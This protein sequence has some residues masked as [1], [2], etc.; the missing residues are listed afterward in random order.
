MARVSA[1]S[2]IFL[3]LTRA[4]APTFSCCAPLLYQ[5]VVGQ[6]ALLVPVF[7]LDHQVSSLTGE[8][9]RLMGREVYRAFGYSDTLVA[10]MQC[11][12]Q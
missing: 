7:T 6:P 12:H 9:A 4:A 11:W 5:V 8:I 1:C 3:H 10:S 2:F